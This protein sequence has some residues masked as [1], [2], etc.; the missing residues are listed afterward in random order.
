[1]QAAQHVSALAK[2]LNNSALA[3]GAS[4]ALHSSPQ[5]PSGRP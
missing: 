1:M 5:T 3:V 2:E 4:H